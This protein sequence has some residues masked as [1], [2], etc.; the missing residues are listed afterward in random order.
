[1]VVSVELLLLLMQWAQLHQQVNY[2]VVTIT[3]LAAV[4]VVQAQAEAKQLVDLVAVDLVAITAD[5][6]TQQEQL[7]QAVAEAVVLTLVVP[8]QLVVQGLLL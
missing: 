2:Q 6:K 4:A 3:T 5:S 8:V 7:T 1:M